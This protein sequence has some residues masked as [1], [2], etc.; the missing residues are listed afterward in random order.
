MDEQDNICKKLRKESTD[1]QYFEKASEYAYQ[2]IKNIDSRNVKPTDSAIENLSY[3]KENLPAK[4][5]DTY[6]ILRLLHEYA[7]PA[8]IAQTGGRYYGFVC[9]GAVPAALAAK[10]LSVVWDQNAAMNVLSPVAAALEDVCEDWVVDL[11]RLPKETAAGLVGGSSA[12]T[13]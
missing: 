11:L 1:I 5:A 2:Y 13:I 6:E 3:F 8:T 7:S 12:A 10:W 9:G 4:G